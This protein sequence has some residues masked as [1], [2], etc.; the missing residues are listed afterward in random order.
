MLRDLSALDRDISQPL[1]RIIGEAFRDGINCSIITGGLLA[2]GSAQTVYEESVTQ[3]Y[4]I[5]SKM[6]MIDGREF[7]YQRDGGSGSGIAVMN[8]AAAVVANYTEEV[9]TGYAWAAEAQEGTILIT[10]GNTPAADAWKDGWLVV[11]KVSN[12][13][14]FHK[15]ATNTSHATLP[16]ITL[17][18]PVVSGWLATGELS[19][20]P[21]MFSKTL[22]V[23]TGGLTNRPTGVG[24]IAITASYYYWGC[25][26]GPAPLLVDTAENLT[27]GDEVGHPATCA[28]A[29]ACGV[30]VTLKANYGRVIFVAAADEIA[31]VDLS[32]GL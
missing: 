22:T 23:A 8:Q 19:I 17:Y 4:Y 7:I 15:I 2:G 29:G 31:I 24:L 3:N 14:Q 26:K 30:D 11:N 28:V 10:T 27:I 32:L 25:V 13:G 21:S 1:G 5:G 6:R 12:L 9:Q 18:D 16:Y 20:I